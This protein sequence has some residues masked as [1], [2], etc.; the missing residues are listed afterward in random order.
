MTYQNISALEAFAKYQN[1]EAIL[2]DVREPAEH[3]QGHISGSL[4]LPLSKINNA[5]L[6]KSNKEIIVYCQKGLR[7]QKACQ[8]LINE[9][10]SLSLLNIEGGI[11]SWQSAQLSIDKPA[12]NTLSLDR[13]VQ[14]FIGILLILF[15]GLSLSI[16]SSFTWA[17]MF[18]GAGLLI[19]GSTGFCG[20]AR[21]LAIMPW[22][23]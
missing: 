7:G 22:N 9:N 5:A 18:I 3:Q 17:I 4:L 13:Q 20:L 16:S 19:A 14:L 11:E 2:I 8:K 12:T 1:N 23:R 21:L 15:S 10:A 6:P